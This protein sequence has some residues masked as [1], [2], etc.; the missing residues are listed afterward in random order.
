MSLRSALLSVISIAV[1]VLLIAGLVAL[2]KVDLL[3]VVHELRTASRFAI[4]QLTLLMT[5][6]IFLSSQKWRLMDKVIR[7]PSDVPL[8][9]FGFFAVTSAGVALG[10][11]LPM[12]VSMVV[13]RVL[14]THFHGRALTRGTVGTI[15]DQ[16]TDFLIVCCLIPASVVTRATTGGPI[17]WLSTAGGMALLA[18]CAAEYSVRLVRR[19]AAHFSTTD[20]ERPRKWQQ[21]LGDLLHSGLLETTLVRKLLGLSVLRFVVLVLMAGQTSH[22]IGAAVP[23]W[24]LAAAMPFVVVSSAL[25]LTPGGIGLNELTYTTALHVFGTPVS[26][27][28]QWAL[29]NRVLT[30]VAALTV[31][32]CT[33]GILLIFKGQKMLRSNPALDGVS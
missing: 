31:S 2:A 3:A 30:A 22:A 21:G 19:A 24:H 7:R 11:A 32:A 13:A 6:N 8:S 14:G 5:L 1:A 17:L 33:F 16:G 28:A 29:A 12:Q 26:A 4:A 18:L 20:N 9:P 15:F 10:Q 23:L 27:A 25:A